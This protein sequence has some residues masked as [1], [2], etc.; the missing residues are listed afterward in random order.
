M[1]LPLST[2]LLHG[3]ALAV[4][5]AAA[6]PAFAEGEIIVELR[7]INDRKSVFGTVQAADTTTARARIAGTVV[8]LSIDE[9]SAVKEGQVIARVLDAKLAPQLK[10]VDSRIQALRSRTNLADVELERTRKLYKKGTVSRA[11][12]DKAETARKVLGRDLSAMRS[13]RAVIAQRQTEGRVLAPAAGRVLRVNV[14]KGKSVLAGETIASIT[15]NAFVLRLRLPERHARFIKEGDS[16]SLDRDH[17]GS[18]AR[19]VVRQVY[20]EIQQ[21]RVV[22]DV[23]VDGLGDFFVGERIKVLITAGSRQS[24]VVPESYLFRRFGLTFVRL[25]GAGDVVVQ[26]GQ[27]SEGGIEIL[28]GLR[29]GDRLLPPAE[30]RKE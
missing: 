28:S 29:A 12:L 14:T 17:S 21:G 13:E 23:E 2:A 4:A 3:L 5:L 22:A 26:H 9:G 11:R 18:A 27:T 20:P 19:G 25:H 16:V 10:A 15:A 8:D 6:P 30:D 24:I 7:T 1:R